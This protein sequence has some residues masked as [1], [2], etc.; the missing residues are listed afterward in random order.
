MATL[1]TAAAGTG[2]DPVRLAAAC[3]NARSALAGADHP[4]DGV[5]A[6]L[7]A[8]AAELE[9]TLLSVFVLEHEKLW[10]VAQRGYT[11]ISDGLST[12]DGVMGRAVRARKAQL[13]R[14]VT[15]DPDYLAAAHGVVS[16]LAMPLQR[17]GV[18]VGL[19]N[20]ESTSVLPANAVRI[21]RSFARRLLPVAEELRTARRFDLSALARLFVYLSSLRDPVA[22]ADIVARS[23]PRILPVQTSQVALL[24]EDGSVE[25][26]ARWRAPKGSPRPLSVEEIGL[27]RG[28]A[29][30]TAVVELLT[31][32]AG[33]GGDRDRSVV[34]LPLRAGAVEVGALVGS[35]GRRDELDRREAEFAALLAA[36]TAAS[37]DAALALSRER[38]NA[39]T[40][41]LTGLHNR[42]GFEERL[43]REIVSAQERRR[44]ITVLVLDC[45][46]FKAVNDRAGHEFGDALLQE[47]GRALELFVPVQATSA[48]LGGD[49]FVVLLPDTDAE[50]AHALADRLRRRLS[51]ALAEAGFPLHV[52]GGYATYPFDGPGTSHLLRGADQALYAAKALGKD[53]ILGIREALSGSDR[54]VVVEGATANERRRPP[55]PS[56]RPMLSELTEADDAIWAEQT[57]TEVLERLC[58]VLTFVVGATGCLAS[59]VEGE[60]LYDVARHALREVDLGDEAA[61]LISDFPLTAEVLQSG[62]SRSVSFLDPEI[63]P[64]EAFV[65]RDLDMNCVLLLPL[66]VR[67]RPWALVELYDV[68]LRHFS[69]AERSTAEFLVRQAARRIETI[70]AID[71][72][73][74]PELPVV[75][76]PRPNE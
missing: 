62:E 9:G 67:G 37:L 47:V 48:R 55:S 16:E 34:W 57:H 58:K 69:D 68:R 23:L 60:Y 5:E 12:D 65:L 72:R 11:M 26:L 43:E 8:F 73:P 45:D 42:R 61:Y 14:D 66:L 39:L 24:G 13:V 17:D 30:P 54:P 28:L 19:L 56:E 53:R 59:R 36:H 7:A 41:P 22:I 70:S 51:E 32:P 63:D 40:D 27:T 35:S 49:E 1:T 3:R 18:V 31:R 74:L 76:V 44:P 75:R 6:A 29:D 10:I 38:H 33:R 2:L 20:I 64:A 50:T 4:A 52:S 21:V 15:L 71:G 46:D 25:E